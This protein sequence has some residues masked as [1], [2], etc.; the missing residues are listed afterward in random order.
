MIGWLQDKEEEEGEEDDEDE[1]DEDVIWN[2]GKGK[3]TNE[4]ILEVIE[5]LDWRK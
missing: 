4:E 3:G 2:I 1:D 5:L